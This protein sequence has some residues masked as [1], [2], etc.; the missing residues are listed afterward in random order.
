[1]AVLKKKGN[2][3]TMAVAVIFCFFPIFVFRLSQFRRKTPAVGLKGPCGDVLL[4][5]VPAKARSY[6]VARPTFV[7][8][9]CCRISSTLIMC[10]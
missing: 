6:C 4:S 9:S 1:M 10:W 3:K 8:S 2:A 7:M 5:T